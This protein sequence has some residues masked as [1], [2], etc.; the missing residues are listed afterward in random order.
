MG[1]YLLDNPPKTR[2]FR[3]PR[4]EKPSGVVVVHTA[5]NTPD[6]TPED[7]GAESVASF[8]ADRS[9]YGSY[10]ALCDSDS[11]VEMVPP[12]YEAFHDATGSNPHSYGISGATRADRWAQMPDD[13]RDGCVEMMAVAAARYARWIKSHHGIVIPAKRISRADSEARRPG[14]ISHAERDPARRTDPGAAFPWE[15]FLDLY[16]QELDPVTTRGAQVD[17]A[18]KY[19]RL[20]TQA[21]LEI[22]GGAERQKAADEA[23]KHLRAGRRALRELPTL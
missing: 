21:A 14:F 23:V 20:A 17:A 2:Q 6:T 15:Q 16:A 10:H 9:D 3:N 13:W 11:V 7:R 12:T 19:A 4:R 22:K 5:E 1:Y 8:I 18:L